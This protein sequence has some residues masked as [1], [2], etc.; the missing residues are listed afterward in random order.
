VIFQR[1]TAQPVASDLVALLLLYNKS[2]G[3]FM[4]P[5]NKELMLF[6]REL[7]NNPTRHEKRL[8]YG[9]LKNYPLQFNRQKILMNYIA[10]FYC[11]KANLVIELDGSQHYT[12]EGM[13]YDLA[14]EK[15]LKSL[16]L[17]VLRFSNLDIDENFEGVCQSIDRA[18]RCRTS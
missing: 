12:R 13:A 3:D 6:A 16:G 9:Y 2:V 14:R 17:D 15:A 8:W 1:V 4:L 5:Q 10:D 11:A 7:R 18:V